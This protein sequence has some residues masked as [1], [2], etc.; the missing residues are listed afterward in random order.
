ME[1]KKNRLKITVENPAI[2]KEW[3]YEG[4]IGINPETLTGGS[5]K[6]VWW[7]CKLGHTWQAQINKRFSRGQ[8]CP[9]CSNKKVWVGFNDLKTT[10]PDIAAQWD[11]VKNGTLRP[12]QFTIGADIKICWKCK[13]GYNWKAL[14]YSR[15]NSDCP[16]CA[17]NIL[18][19]GVN[20]L[21]TVNPKLASEWDAELNGGITPDN[22][23]ANNNKK[24]WWRCELGHSWQAGVAERNRGNGCPYCAN[25][26][27][28]RGFNDLQTV[29]P[30][31]AAEWNYAKN[32]GLRPEDVV[33][34]SH[35]IVWWM[36]KYGHEWQAKISNRLRGNGCPYDAG[37]MVIKGKTDLK[38]C[39][40]KLCE[41]WDCTKNE[42]TPDTV[43]CYSSKLFWWSCPKGHSYQASSAN[44][45]KGTGCPYC[46]NKRP[47]VGETDF[48][49]VH[50]ELVDE[51]DNEKNKSLRPEHVVPGSHKKVWW[52]CKEE[53][54][55]RTAV[56]F[57]HYG[58][59]CPI[60]ARFVNHHPVIA[61]ETDL[62]A[63][64]PDIAKEWDDERNKDLTPHDVLP[65]SNQIVW[66]K[67]KRGHSWKTKVQAR[68]KGTLCPRCKGKTPM[69]TRLI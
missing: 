3:D 56:Y 67:C 42:Q 47:I 1:I 55:W 13:C 51:W 10:H 7:K 64:Y 20:D 66:W 19:P 27:L 2:M 43:A 57:R 29:A 33:T 22:I 49:S 40:P 36:C 35:R 59:K 30:N 45:V 31:L 62:A 34:G 6:I 60:C 54:S 9:Y 38:T 12:E 28:L 39:Y 50:P 69:R 24:M 63:L 32:K 18:T 17:G 8:N 37:K 21:Q 52:R 65:N 16:S 41:E 68:I 15:K 44:R 11:D 23:A 4:N 46:K 5:N 26:R 53:H 25:R 58:S 61:G 48:A 14:L